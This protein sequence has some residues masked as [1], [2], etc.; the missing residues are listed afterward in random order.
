[1]RP[2]SRPAPTKVRGGGAASAG[3]AEAAADGAAGDHRDEG[4]D[5]LAGLLPELKLALVANDASRGE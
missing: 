1:M 5:N 2:R 3:A 4:F